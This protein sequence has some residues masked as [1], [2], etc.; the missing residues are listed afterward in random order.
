MVVNVVAAS[1]L[2]RLHAQSMHWSSLCHCA[3]LVQ[4]CDQA[5]V[6][7]TS[8]MLFLSLSLTPGCCLCCAA[9]RRV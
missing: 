5:Y 8:I 9:T 1:L 2:Q 3:L 6:I 7:I 4:L